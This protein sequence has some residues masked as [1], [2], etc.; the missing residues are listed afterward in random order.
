VANVGQYLSDVSSIAPTSLVGSTVWPNV[1]VEAP[2]EVFGFPVVVISGGF[3]PPTV[4]TGDLVLVNASNIAA[5][6]AA[7][8]TVSHSKSSYFYHMV[9][10]VDMNSDGLLDILTARATFPMFG[11]VKGELLW[12]EH[13]T[14]G[15]DAWG[16]AWTEHAMFEGPDAMFATAD[17]NGDGKFEVIAP[18]F[19]TKKLVV[20]WTTGTYAAGPWHNHVVDSTLDAMMGVIV[21]DIN[22][23]GAAEIVGTN[24]VATASLS[25]I[26]A[27]EVPKDLAT[28]TWTRHTLFNN[29]PTTLSGNNQASPGL[30]ILCH[31]KSPAPASEKPLIVLGGDGAEKV[32]LLEPTST[33]FAYNVSEI[34]AWK[35]TAGLCA[36]GDVDGDG[37]SEIFAPNW[38]KGYVQVFQFTA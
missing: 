38:D 5:A 7:T 23:D 11:T 32:F 18:Q 34:V 17:L 27:W 3:L 10:F 13:P 4:S 21:A 29:I 12:L 35:G 20:Y 22:G 6:G 31:A 16:T 15:Q 8:K 37:W 26:Y 19:F 33:S 30:P 24:H 14:K 9:Q 25:G 28:G 36:C 1:V 2:A